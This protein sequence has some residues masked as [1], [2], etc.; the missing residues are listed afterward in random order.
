MVTELKTQI[1]VWIDSAT[2]NAYK[3]L[4]SREKLRPAEGLEEFLKVVNCEGS[5]AA[6]LQLLRSTADDE[7]VKAQVEV[8]MKWSRQ[9]K[10]WFYDNRGKQV[11]IKGVLLEKLG[12]I[13]DPRL[14]AEVEALLKE[15]KEE[16]EHVTPSSFKN[17][18][19]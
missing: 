19:G 3:M 17:L 2:W 13:R 18:L 8:L 12:K 5:V 9:G 7:G 6:A 11:N 4:C 15:K 1:G 16:P 10:Y 14:R